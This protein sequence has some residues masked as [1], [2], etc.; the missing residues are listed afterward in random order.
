MHGNVLEWCADQYHSNYKGAPTNGSAWIE[1]DNDNDN[2]YRSLRGG[3]W[4]SIPMYCRS[5]SRYY[6]NRAVR[7]GYSYIVGFRVVC[8]VARNL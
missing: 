3:S 2:L 5:A 6:N 7:E 8:A 4:D 1:D